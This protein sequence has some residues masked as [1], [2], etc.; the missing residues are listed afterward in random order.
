MPAPCLGISLLGL[1]DYNPAAPQIAY[2]TVGEAAAALSVALLIPTFLRRIYRFRLRA[3]STPLWLVYAVVFAGFLC[4]A[5]A[6]LIPN[7]PLPRDLIF[8]FPIF[9]EIV[10][11]G[12]FATAFVILAMTLV[13]PTPRPG[14]FPHYV[15]N[16]AAHLAEANSDDHVDFVRDLEAI[17][18]RLAATASFLQARTERS[19][20]FDFIHRKKILDARYANS[21]FQIL[22][23]PAF[24]ET[25]VSR[26]PWATASIVRKLSTK[27]QFWGHS[28]GFFIRAVVRRAI[29]SPTSLMDR[30]IDFWGFG[31]AP[32]LSESL[33]SS[34][35]V[36]RHYE[37]FSMLHFDEKE[38]D[39]GVVRRL[40]DAADKTLDCLFESSMLWEPQSVYQLEHVYDSIF[41]TARSR[42]ESDWRFSHEVFSGVTDIVKKARETL[43]SMDIRTYEAFF[44]GEGE[45][46]MPY[47][48]FHA[49][50]ELVYEGMASIA[51]DF[52][53]AEDSNWIS[54]HELFDKLFPQYGDLPVG[55]DPLQQLTLIKIIEKV[56]ENMEGWYPSMSRLLLPLVG[57]IQEA[58]LEKR[59]GF[60]ILKI[61]L[62]Q[63]LARLKDLAEKQPEKLSHFIPSNVTF[64]PDQQKLTFKY[65]NGRE[66]TCSLLMALPNLSVFSPE[67]RAVQPA[68]NG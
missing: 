41:L 52:K 54:A 42:N 60:G 59:T 16:A 30:E 32:V 39:R 65:A 29:V 7:L 26:V 4:A 45:A 25:L 3:R 6:A 12:L 9:W 68:R 51:N 23:D 31:A 17:V 47:H 24:C 37:P 1:C 61:L 36:H 58:D 56:K 35:Y 5:L 13:P 11:G 38:L 50:A 8:F 10:G 55:L 57:P 43:S 40:N 28:P 34:A 53:G 44:Q 22:A 62:F 14:K 21:F 18:S 27:E 67:L 49:L 19:A 46:K 20:F 63:E 48:I 33:F 15:Q 64:D 2:F 66:R